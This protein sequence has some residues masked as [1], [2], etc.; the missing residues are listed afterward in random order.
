M[1]ISKHS[2]LF[3]LVHLS[4]VV[5]PSICCGVQ[6]EV[7]LEYNIQHMD[8]RIFFDNMRLEVL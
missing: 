6:T 7:S 5:V 1:V 8:I 3:E 2:F 4:L